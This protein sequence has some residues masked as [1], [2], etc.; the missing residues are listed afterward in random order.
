MHATAVGGDSGSGS[1]G[2]GDILGLLYIMGVGVSLAFVALA[3]Q[4]RGRGEAGPRGDLGRV[5]GSLDNGYGRG[6][7]KAGRPP[8]QRLF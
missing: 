7:K 6:E 1:T 2:V 5:P 3:Y 8:P 4:V